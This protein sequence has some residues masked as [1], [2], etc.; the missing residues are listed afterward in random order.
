MRA[1]TSPLAS[2]VCVFDVCLHQT[3][4]AKQKAALRAEVVAVRRSLC[5]ARD[6]MH[7]P[8]CN[9]LSLPLSLSFRLYTPTPRPSAEMVVPLSCSPA[10]FSSSELVS[11]LHTHMGLPHFAPFAHSILQAATRSPADTHTHNSHLRR[12]LLRPSISILEVLESDPALGVKA[13]RGPFYSTG[14]QPAAALCTH[15]RGATGQATRIPPPPHAPNPRPPSSRRAGRERDSH[16]HDQRR[17]PRCCEQGLCH[18]PAL[19]RP[20]G[21]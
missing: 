16:A 17:G 1:V 11:I 5:P 8:G 19:G 15:G 13:S 3:H 2:A 6:A 20:Q 9:S 12:S 4:K 7:P 14:T 10:C 18:G 21:K